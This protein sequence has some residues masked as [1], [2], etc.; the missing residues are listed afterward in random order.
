MGIQVETVYVVVQ[1][2]NISYPCGIKGASTSWDIAH[3]IEA[4]L[5]R[6]HGGFYLIVPVECLMPE[7][8]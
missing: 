2:G 5:K 4:K 8:E 1:P 6:E 7:E 3:K